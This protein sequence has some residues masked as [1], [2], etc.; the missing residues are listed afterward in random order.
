MKLIL[1]VRGQY[2]KAKVQLPFSPNKKESLQWVGMDKRY[3]VLYQARFHCF[4]LFALNF[5]VSK[6]TEFAFLDVSTMIYTKNKFP[7]RL[8]IYSFSP[9]FG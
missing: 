6:M 7:H 2:G 9:N 4:C 3:C 1:H 8:F 5:G